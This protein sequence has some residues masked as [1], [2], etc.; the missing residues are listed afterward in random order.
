M[1]L[2]AVLLERIVQGVKPSS[3]GELKPVFAI[4]VNLPRAQEFAHIEVGL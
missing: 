2:G 1:S 3:D 4:A